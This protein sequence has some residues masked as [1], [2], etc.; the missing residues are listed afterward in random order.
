MRTTLYILPI[1]AA[2]LLLSACGDAAQPLPAEEFDGTP[3]VLAHGDL[4]TPDLPT[5]YPLTV[6]RVSLG[7]A[8]FHDGL[9]SR[10]G[11]QSCASCHVQGDGFSDIRRYS[12]GVRGLP[13]TRQAMPIVNLAWHRD[14]FFWDGRSPT[15]RDQALHPI[16]DTLEMDETIDNVIRK[17]SASAD[18]VRHFTRAFGSDTIT[19]ERIGIALEQFML[20]LVSAGSKY[21]RVQ[22]GQATFTEA[23][24]RG[25][26]LFNTEFDPRG[27]VK[28]AE[29]FHCHAAPF[30]TD[31]RYR[32]NGLDDDAS[33]TDEGR[34]SVTG[35]PRDMAS[36]KVPTLRNIDRTAPY[37]HDGRF[38]TLE[39]VVDFY[40]TGVRRSQSVDPL[41]QY[42]LQPGGLKLSDQDKA[43]LVAFLKTL[44]DAAFLTD[45]KYAKP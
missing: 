2:S 45:A 37:M 6:Q 26:K 11:E 17:L 14:G 32:N 19:P 40:N 20:S 8:L 34:Y 10:T 13:G 4:P 41:M 9:L 43:D 23:E 7:R 21:D 28:G 39:E 38:A 35:V 31:D 25:N 5:D 16:R 42:N 36:F 15:L 44:T 33:M 30:F 18:Y 27:R 22:R 1:L 29:C 24:E 3:Y 12:I